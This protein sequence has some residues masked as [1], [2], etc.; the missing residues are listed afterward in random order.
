[1]IFR[2]AWMATVIALLA[3]SVNAAPILLV[4][5]G[6]LQG[7]TGVDVE[8]SIYDVRFVDGT[9]AALFTGCDQVTDFPFQTAGAA[10]AAAQALLDTVF[11]DGPAGKFDTNPTLINGCIAAPSFCNA[12]NPY[13]LTAALTASTI[14]AHN[15]PLEVLDTL[16]AGAA[17]PQFDLDLVAPVTWAVFTPAVAVPEPASLTL[18][19]LGSVGVACYRRHRRR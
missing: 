7:A 18:L 6:I 16:G 10:S 5:G 19:A 17:P 14:H 4:S 9:C 12:T 15:N 1:M 3:G 2:V 13:T 11:V 8:G